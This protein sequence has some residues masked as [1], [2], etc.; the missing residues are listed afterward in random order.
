MKIVVPPD[1]GKARGPIGN[2]AICEELNLAASDL[3]AG[4]FR[5]TDACD[6]LGLPVDKN[7][8]EFY[9]RIHLQTPPSGHGASDTI[10]YCIASPFEIKPKAPMQGELVW[11]RIRISPPFFDDSHCIARLDSVCRESLPIRG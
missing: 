2:A 11:S 6:E 8:P 1:C 9:G 10:L 4:T 7:A 5:L 3:D